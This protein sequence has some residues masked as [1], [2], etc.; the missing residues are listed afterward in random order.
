MTPDQVIAIPTISSAKP[1]SPKN[2]KLSRAPVPRNRLG[3]FVASGGGHH[4]CSPGVGLWGL[5]GRGDYHDQLMFPLRV[6]RDQL[7]EALFCRFL[8]VEAG[9]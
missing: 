9:D 4:A 7:R 5:P 3:A 8:R 2:A 6:F 1:S